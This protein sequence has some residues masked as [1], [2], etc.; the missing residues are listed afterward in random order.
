[1]EEKQRD[2]ERREGREEKKMKTDNV[3]SCDFM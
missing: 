3:I 1:M 2:G